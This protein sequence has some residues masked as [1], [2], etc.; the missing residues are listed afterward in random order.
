MI[1]SIKKDIQAKSK[2]GIFLTA[3]GEHVLVHETEPERSHA[4]SDGDG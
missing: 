4:F 2:G 3:R 1:S